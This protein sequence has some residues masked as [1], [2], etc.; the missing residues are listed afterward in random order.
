MSH[1]IC[2]TYTLIGMLEMMVRSCSMQGEDIIEQYTNAKGCVFTFK[3]AI[4]RSS[5][6]ILMTNVTR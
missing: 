3:Y 1:E 6:S 4:R 5:F 2:Q